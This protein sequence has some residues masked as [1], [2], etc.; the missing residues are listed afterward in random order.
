M[1]EL[2]E[3]VK[4]Y[5]NKYAGHYDA[6]RDTPHFSRLNQIQL[7]FLKSCISMS[8][9]LLEVGC[10]TG[11]FLK[12]FP[13]ATGIDFSNCMI[14]IAKSK[15]LRVSFADAT[16][17]PFNDDSFDFVYSFKVFAHV[18][19]CEKMLSEMARVAKKGIVFDFYDFY[20]L[21]AIRDSI[22]DC[23]KKKTYIR[24]DKLSS[25]KFMLKKLGLRIEKTTRFKGYRLV[26]AV[27]EKKLAG[28]E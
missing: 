7:D 15:G 25:I 4:S 14:K 16:S 18:P 17:L 21:K 10:G 6:S 2:Q 5:Y 1:N 20:S 13:K 24:H 19:N 26:F 8:E 12:N 11:L 3:S 22:R 28:V 23:L 27:A 9:N